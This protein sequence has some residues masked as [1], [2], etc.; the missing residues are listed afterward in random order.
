MDMSVVIGSY[1]QCDQ[2]KK[3]VAG[4]IQQQCQIQYEVIIVDSFSSDGTRA[5]VAEYESRSLPFKLTFLQRQ[6]PAG[7]AE[8]RNVG[9]HQATSPWVI[10]TDADM[11]PSAT[12]VQSHYDAHQS[13]D[14]PGCFEGLAYNLSSYEWPPEDHVASP[15]VPS[16]YRAGDALDWYYFLT[17]NISFPRSIFMDHQGFSHDFSNYGWEDLELGYRLKKQGVPLH[18]LPSAINYHY[19]VITDQEKADRKLLMG[20]SAQV[21]MQKHPE[22]KRFLGWNM[23]S[24][25]IRKKLTR[26]HG[27]YRLISSFRRSKW[28]FLKSFSYWFIGEYNYLTGLLNMAEAS[29]P[30]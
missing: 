1:N 13:T 27:I 4:Y 10:I 22:L 14:T 28:A 8:A 7:K 26:S 15:Q 12:F 29:G 2:L 11:I 24:I 30:D 6:N 9:V 5:M 18:Y 25:F 20:Q 19:H 3:V 21:F 16:K 23:V 17:G